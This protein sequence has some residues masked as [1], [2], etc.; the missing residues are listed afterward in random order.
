VSTADISVS[1]PLQRSHTLPMS[2]DSLSTL[3]ALLPIDHFQGGLPEYHYVAFTKFPLVYSLPL[4][5][6]NTVLLPKGVTNKTKSNESRH[7]TLTRA[8][9]MHQPPLMVQRRGKLHPRF[10]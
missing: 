9:T 3:G 6:T 5:R 8:S 10:L 2:H 1:N 7:S 4:G